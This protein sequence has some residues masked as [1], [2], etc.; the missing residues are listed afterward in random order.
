MNHRRSKICFCL[1]FALAPE[2]GHAYMHTRSDVVTWRK[3]LP[4]ENLVRPAGWQISN[5]RIDWNVWPTS[6]HRRNGL[7]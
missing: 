1:T 4:E 5:S 7:A 3:W 2:A 6:I